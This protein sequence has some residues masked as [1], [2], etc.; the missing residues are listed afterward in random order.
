MGGTPQ[1]VVRAATL[2]LPLAIAII[3]GQPERFAPLAA[4]YREA[5]RKAGHDP[6]KLKVGINSHGFVAGTTQEAIDAF[7][8]PYAEVMTR[9]GRERGWPP[10][11]RAHFD[12]GR[13]PGGAL[14]VGSVDDVVEKLVWEHGIFGCDRFLM[15][16]SLGAVRHDKVMRASELLGT[17]VAPRV[18]ARIAEKNAA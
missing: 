12:A 4:L 6:A 7:F 1:S 8:P 5:G 9:I 17:Q 18:R 11:T 10:T 13:G 2:G 16:M 15:Q 14:L 3:G